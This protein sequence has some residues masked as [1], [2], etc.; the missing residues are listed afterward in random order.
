MNA[1]VHCS[2]AQEHGDFLYSL[3]YIK[4]AKRII[5]GTTEHMN[6]KGT[7]STQT[8]LNGDRAMHGEG[9]YDAETGEMF[10]G[11]G[12]SQMPDGV[13]IE[14]E[15]RNLV[16]ISSYSQLG[17]VIDAVYDGKW[18]QKTR[19]K[20][21]HKM[22]RDWFITNK[23]EMSFPDEEARKEEGIRY[24][25]VTDRLLASR[26]KRIRPV[27]DAVKALRRLEEQR[28]TVDNQA[29]KAAQEKVIKVCREYMGNTSILA[30]GDSAY[31]VNL[32]SDTLSYVMKENN[33]LEK[34]LF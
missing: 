1:T 5:I 21:I 18:K 11:S 22:V 3:Q 33:Y 23:L 26:K 31:R 34:N 4:G 17:K 9:Y 14:D 20:N 6:F 2:M 15:R 7:D 19:V 24:K 8:L 32:V 25:N 29:L 28:D 10:R 13:Y 27:Q 12:L 16:R 30:S